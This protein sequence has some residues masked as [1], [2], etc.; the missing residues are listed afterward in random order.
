MPTRDDVARLAGTSTAVVSYVLNNG[1]RPVSAATK[2]K[3]LAAVA[4]LDYRPNGVARSLRAR[5]TT[6]LGLIVP[7]GSNPYFARIAQAVEEAAYRR[8]YTVLIGSAMDDAARELAYVQTFIDRRVD[9]ILYIPTHGA[10]C[11]SEMA[12]ARVPTVLLDRVVD[13]LDASS[14]T[15][16]NVEGARLATQH[17]I[18]HG[19]RRIAFIGGPQQLSP[20]RERHAGWAQAMRAAKLRPLASLQVEAAFGLE[21]GYRAAIRLLRKRNRP[22]AIFT[23]ADDQAIGA[24]R[25]AYELNLTVPDDVAFVSFDGT[26]EASFTVPSLCCVRQPITQLADRAVELLLNR[27]TDPSTPVVPDRLA[28]SLATGGSCGCPEHPAR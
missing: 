22:T 15:P 13:G 26:T 4:E 16:D 9:G 14:V 11:V 25:A 19:H 17:L 5:T 21:A 2:A 6:A 10:D 18:D 24:L 12:K 7:D 3:V 23:S 28:V 20:S 27:I 8:G 1:P